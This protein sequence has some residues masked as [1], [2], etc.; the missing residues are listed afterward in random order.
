M[1]HKR[2]QRTGSSEIGWRVY[3]VTGSNVLNNPGIEGSLTGWN[4]SQ[5]AGSSVAYESGGAR[6]IRT[7]V[8]PN[9]NQGAKLTLGVP[10]ELK[11]SISD[12]VGTGSFGA[13]EGAGVQTFT[14]PGIKTLIYTPLT[15]QS[16]IINAVTNG[17]NFRVE[18][19][20]ARRMDIGMSKVVLTLR[21]YDGDKK[22][23]SVELGPV[24]DGA[25]YVTREGQAVAI[26]DAVNAVAG[27]IAGYDFLAQSTE[28]NNINTATP[29]FQTH[30]RWLVELFDS[31]TGDGPYIFD[32]PTADLGTAGLFL[33]AS[34][35]HDPA[36]AAWIALKAALNGIAINPRTGSTM[37][38]GRIYLEE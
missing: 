37:T 5:P 36:H 34:V 14:T 13:N 16:F 10:W 11:V 19:A 20:S 12:I 9:I 3:D 4:V 8:T 15:S 28:P 29:L 18:W 25:S 6:L 2:R 33:P 17:A 26:R 31:V 21:D 27:N 38:V 24:T 30:V 35:E 32:I 7:T 23:T 1:L 22:Q